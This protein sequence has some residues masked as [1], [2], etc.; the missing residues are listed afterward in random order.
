MRQRIRVVAYRLAVIQRGEELGGVADLLDVDAQRVQGS[1]I[2][3]GQIAAALD[4]LALAP[5]Q[6][7]GCEL[8]QRT[9]ALV[10]CGLVR[11][12]FPGAAVKQGDQAQ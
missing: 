6:D 4:D 3:P 2:Q 5:C 9:G 11:E 1:G 10:G 7:R 8:R 12:S